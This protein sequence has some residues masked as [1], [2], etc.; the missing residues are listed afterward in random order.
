MAL[1]AFAWWGDVYLQVG[2][3]RPLYEAYMK[4]T[5][6]L[7]GGLY[8]RQANHLANPLEIER[9]RNKA[10]IISKAGEWGI[11]SNLALKIVRCESGFDSKAIG[12]KGKSFGLWQIHL[13]AHPHITKEQALNPIWSTE[14]AMEKLKDGKAKIWSC[15]K[16]L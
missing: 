7:E 11:D 1:N 10:I 8:L 3:Q 5:A 6:I 14:W 2:G 13:P 16:T 15:L 12:D 9:A 4:P